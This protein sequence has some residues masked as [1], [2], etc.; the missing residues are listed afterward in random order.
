MDSQVL[1]GW[2]TKPC[3]TTHIR[4]AVKLPVDDGFCPPRYDLWEASI[5]TR[6]GTNVCPGADTA[7]K[8]EVDEIYMGGKEK[9]KNDSKKLNA[10]RGS[11]GKTAV[12]GAKD[13]EMGHVDAKVTDTVDGESLR[14]SFTSVYSL[15][16]MSSQMRPRLTGACP[17]C[18]TGRLST[19]QR[20]TLKGRYIPMALN[21]LGLC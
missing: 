18:I 15:V 1:R 2:V 20:K 21:L 10:G 8:V 6:I 19:L 3:V 16:F 13:R 11:V 9:N 5:R 4:S 12:V 17:E 7:H 14:I